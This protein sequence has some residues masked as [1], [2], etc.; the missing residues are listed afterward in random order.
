MSL[1]GEACEDIRPT[2]LDS[3]RVWYKRVQGS[4]V[5]NNESIERLAQGRD[6]VL[7]GLGV[8]TSL[9]SLSGG[10]AAALKRFLE[11]A[12]GI[13]D[14]QIYSMSERQNLAPD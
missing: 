1:N 13:N 12:A 14:R 4:D 3:T 7:V 10:Q 9:T 6:Q 2:R 8:A 11:N 5:D